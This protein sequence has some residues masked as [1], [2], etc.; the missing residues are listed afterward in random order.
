MKKNAYHYLFFIIIFISLF[1]F[2]TIA[3]PL[4]LFDSDDWGY[5]TF[6]RRA[7]PNLY[8]WNPTR[9]FPEVLY[10][11]CSKIAAYMVYPFIH[12]Y[13]N[14]LNI[15]S[16][17]ILSAIIIIYLYLFYIICKNV[18]KADDKT[19]FF[20]TLLFLISH[21]VIIDSEKLNGSFLFW[22]HNLSCV[23]YYTIPSLI[24][25]CL[26]F[27][28]IINKNEEKSNDHKSLLYR[29]IAI[30]VIYL[31]INSNLYQ[32]AI[33]ILYVF[34][35]SFIS[36]I[37]NRTH[38]RKW[39]HENLNNLAIL[40]IWMFSVILESKGPRS[41]ASWLGVTNSWTE[42][43]NLSLKYLITMITAI[44]KF[45]YVL[46]LLSLIAIVYIL[47]KDKKYKLMVLK[48]LASILLY[49]I[50]LVVV[51]SKV[52][53]DYNSR[54][55]VTFGF[56][57]YAVLIV[58]ISIIWLIDNIK[59]LTIIMPFIMFILANECIGNIPQYSD[60]NITNMNSGNVYEIDQ[61]MVSEIISAS[62]K[63]ISD[64]EIKVPKFS[65]SNENWPLSEG[66]GMAISNTLY[67][68]N[69]IN[70]RVNVKIIPDKTLNHKYDIH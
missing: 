69:I 1:T 29:G 4:F 39:F 27:L 63:S 62:E 20:C 45:Y 43:L 59:K 49:F 46:L 60:Y 67:T 47:L 11:F 30:V 33:L 36:F 2:F 23:Y 50:F 25:A 14:A 21:F 18:M 34:S 3:H 22:A 6:H 40:F 65:D 54:M 68:Y 64:I 53:P 51:N 17:T 56:W 70:R 7:I 66:V 9:I 57:F 42:N 26:V 52:S 41:K 19:S 48:L 13:V 31:A 8:E 38:I 44:N 58:N 16:G 5:C 61:Y 28:Y 55:D 24:N 35:E 32:S 10:P 12:D 15:V 37:L